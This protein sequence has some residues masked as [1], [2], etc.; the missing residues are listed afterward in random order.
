MYERTLFERLANPQAEQ[1]TGDRI[2]VSIVIESV[3]NNLRTVFNTRQGSVMIREDYGL[4]DFS[5]LTLMFR[6]A[7]AHI[8]REIKELIE[9]FREDEAAM[10]DEQRTRRESR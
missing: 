3:M 6:D 7:M 5:D 8:A 10:S 9:S 1:R 2:E 4:S